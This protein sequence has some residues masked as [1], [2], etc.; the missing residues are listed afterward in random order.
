MKTSM[1]SVAPLRSRRMVEAGRT[2]PGS[3]GIQFLPDRHSVMPVVPALADL[4]FVMPGLD[5]GIHLL[6]GNPEDGWPGQARP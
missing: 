6:L 4:S 5:P 3:L 2:T 1:A